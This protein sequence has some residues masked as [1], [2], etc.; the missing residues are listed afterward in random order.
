VAGAGSG[1][2]YREGC[3]GTDMADIDDQRSDDRDGAGRQQTER[4]PDPRRDR[5][6]RE[7]YDREGDDRSRDD[8]P[9]DERYR[10]DRPRYRRRGFGFGWPVR[11]A[12]VV[13][14]ALLLVL[15][16]L[17]TVGLIRGINPF[18]KER[19]DRSQPPLL[20]S[21]QNVSQFHAAVGNFQVVIDI[22]DKVSHIPAAL[23]GERTLFVA[24]GSVDAYVD[25]THLADRDI[26]ITDKTVRI[27]LP[28]PQLSKPSLD[29]QH[30][31]LISQ[32]H[33][34]W[35]RFAAL[36]GAD[37]DPQPVYALAEQQIGEAAK[38]AGIAERAVTNTKAMLTGLMKSLGYEVTFVDAPNS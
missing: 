36:F 10:D 26:T 37:S 24:V 20:K 14:G 2:P 8:R 16:L 33:G 38:T 18:H 1:Y 22:Q 25:F 31:Y 28:R 27:R 30:S 29:T 11:G 15:A 32:Q 4:L 3:E 17:G 21:I 23:A 19:I 9:R 6:G 12:L 5:D 35:N 7:A 13:G 34:L